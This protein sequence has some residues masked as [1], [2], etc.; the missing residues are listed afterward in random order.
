VILIDES[1]LPAREAAASVA[2]EILA[3]FSRNG[4]PEPALVIAGRSVVA[5]EF[6]LMA[7][8]ERR[9]AVECVRQLLSLACETPNVSRHYR[10]GDLLFDLDAGRVGCVVCGQKDSLSPTEVRLLRTLMEYKDAVVPRKHVV[11]MVWGSTKVAARTLDAHISRLR[12]RIEFAGA[13]IES[14]Y[15]DGYSLLT[16]DG[17]EAAR[18]RVA[19]SRGGSTGVGRAARS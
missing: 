10:A 16:S 11:D 9:S 12:K 1:L 4:W 2:R 14:T 17:C 5:V 8:I 19:A 7:A 15:G 3:V 13:R 6:P 18:S